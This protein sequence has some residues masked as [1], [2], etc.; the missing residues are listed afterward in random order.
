MTESVTQRVLLVASPEDVA[1]PWPLSALSDH[2]RRDG[3]D[4]AV[5][6]DVDGADPNDVDVIHAF[7]WIAGRAVAARGPGVPWVLTAPWLRSAT[8][9]DAADVARGAAVALCAS[10]EEANGANRLGV[11]RQRCLV[12]PMGVDVEVF[13]RLGPS[14][15]RTTLHRVIVRAVGPGDGVLDVIAA[16]PALPGTELVILVGGVPADDGR[17]HQVLRDVALDVGVRDRVALVP[18]RDAL[19]R[20][21]LLRSADV[22]VSVGRESGPQELVAEAMACGKAVVVTPTGPQRDLAVHDV[23]GLHVPAGHVRALALALRQ[24][25]ADPF[26]LEGMGLAGAERALSRYAWSR[27]AHEF[28]SVYARV[29]GRRPGA[30]DGSDDDVDVDV[31]WV[32]AGGIGTVAFAAGSSG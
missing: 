1:P 13:T 28:G 31:E 7:G 30:S 18:A 8:G 10:S 16:L 20:S 9:P 12:L 4:V 14:A 27:V 29:S 25:L 17:Y 19:E 32:D 24:L 23:T 22:V 2:L 21:W 3:H 26:T 15:N 11:P 6:D 5:T